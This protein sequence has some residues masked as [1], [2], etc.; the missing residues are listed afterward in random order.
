MNGAG[1]P[2]TTAV[3][4]VESASHRSAG[5]RTSATWLRISRTTRPVGESKRPPFHFRNQEDSATGPYLLAG[6]SYGGYVALEMAS[7][8]SESGD[9][10]E[11]VTV[12][13][14][15]IS[16]EAARTTG[17]SERASLWIRRSSTLH[18][19]HPT[20]ARW[21][22]TRRTVAAMW[23]RTLFAGI[24]A[25]PAGHP[26]DRVPLHRRPGAPEASDTS[27]R[28]ARHRDP[29]SHQQPWT[30]DLVTHCH[31]L[32]GFRRRRRVPRRRR[33]ANRTSA[34]LRRSSIESVI[35]RDQRCSCPAVEER[36]ARE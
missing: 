10:V 23:I 14:T 34:R 7:Q 17:W 33:P 19:N 8:L 30:R 16:T 2:S 18:H 3:H 6:Y 20:N 11:H 21:K 15:R 31:R 5:L 9:T 28:R 22:P 1:C 36:A 29:W 4:L 26:V 32:T 25:V 27:M 13:D 35:E 24:S 12:L